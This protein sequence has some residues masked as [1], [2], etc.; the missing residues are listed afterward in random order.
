MQGALSDLIG[1]KQFDSTPQFDAL[2]A[3][4]KRRLEEESAQLNELFGSQGARFGSDIARGQA[5]L[6]ARFL[7]SESFQR[8]NIA[9][10]SFQNAQDRRLGALPLPGQLGQQQLNQATSAFNIG[11]ANQASQERDL[12][13]EM[14]EF[15]RTQ[16]ALFPQL[17][18]FATAGTEGDTT[19]INPSQ[20]PG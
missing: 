19:I 14:A 17:L 6:S 2:E 16:G 15:A 3:I 9:Q 20:L 11:Q 5:G 10:S 13:R 12:Q 1:G 8:A 4:S 18:G 7:E